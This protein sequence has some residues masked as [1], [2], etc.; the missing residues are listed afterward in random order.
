M[1][2]TFFP[3]QYPNLTTANLQAANRA[4]NINPGPPNAPRQQQ[5]HQQQ[6]SNPVSQ[7]QQ[8]MFYLD[9]FNTKME[10]PQSN[11]VDHASYSSAIS[12]NGVIADE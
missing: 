8:N 10:Q 9:P 5:Q 7:L 1:D 4:F 11:D 12:A 2:Y 6:Q 3:Q